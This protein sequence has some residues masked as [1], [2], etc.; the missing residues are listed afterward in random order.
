MTDSISDNIP[1]GL[2]LFETAINEKFGDLIEKWLK[3][4]ETQ[5]SMFPVT[6]SIGKSTANSR[7]VIHYGY[8]YDYKEGGINQKAPNLPHII[9]ILRSSI[10]NT[11]SSSLHGNLSVPEEMDFLLK[12]EPVRLNQCIINRYLPGQGIGSH[13]DKLEYG[14]VIV[15]FTFL[16]GREME[17]NRENYDSFKLYTH[18]RSMY[19]MTG[20]SRNNWNHQMRPRK[21]DKVNDNKLLRNECFSITFREVL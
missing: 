7:K 18:P 16:S 11:I 21:F 9:E 12:L 19:I 14:D 17:F 1:K 20:E 3:L 10:K 15:C 8:K 5:N 2:F 4:E 13:I 6:N